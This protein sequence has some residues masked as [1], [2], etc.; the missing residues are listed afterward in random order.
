MSSADEK[1][2]MVHLTKSERETVYLG[3]GLLLASKGIKREAK[4]DAMA[5][6][7]RL[8]ELEENHGL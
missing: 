6:L 3:V 4:E 7:R 1:T 2:L 8:Q 5:F